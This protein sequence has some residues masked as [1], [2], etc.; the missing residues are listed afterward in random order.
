[1][2]NAIRLAIVGVWLFLAA[3]CVSAPQTNL[4]EAEPQ[5]AAQMPTPSVT[6]SPLL[7]TP[8]PLPSM[9]ARPTAQVCSPLAGYPLANLDEQVS[10]P[11]HPPPPGIDDPHY[12]VDLADFSQADRVARS[13]MAVQAVLSGR[14]VGVIANRFPYGNTV[15]VE[16]LLHDLDDRILSRFRLPDP[17]VATIQPLALTCPPS[18]LP[19]DWKTRPR[20]LYL[21]YAHLRDA[22]DWNIGRAVAC[23][24]AIGVIGDSGNALVPHLHLEAR[25][26]PAGTLFP[27]MAH[28]DP[29]ATNEEM[30]AYCLWRVSGV[31]QSIN[32]MCLLDDCSSAR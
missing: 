5:I 14:V 31:F 7:P 4:S 13:G 17:P 21:L 12:G 20:S 15:I 25:I 2:S 8:S 1:M 18:A 16:T 32:A 11:Y 6:V 24:E 9:T 29:S 26:G 23:G 19:E 22:P 3:G 27:S 10:N 28:Y 30:A